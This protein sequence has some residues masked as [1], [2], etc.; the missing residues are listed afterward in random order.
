MGELMGARHFSVVCFRTQGKNSHG[1]D[2]SIHAIADA[3]SSR[4]WSLNILQY[5]ECIHL[6]LTYCHVRTGADKTFLVDLKDSVAEV[7][8][9]PIGKYKDGSAAIYGMAASIPDKTEVSK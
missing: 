9:A 8:K 5:P 4:G 1:E 6:C 3:M 7:M 2:L